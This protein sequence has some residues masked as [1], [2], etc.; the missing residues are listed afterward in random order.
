MRWALAGAGIAIVGLVV[1]L[2]VVLRDGDTPAT[3]FDS[4]PAGKTCA[5]LCEAE[6]QCHTATWDR[7]ACA[8]ACLQFAVL[9]E[10]QPACETALGDALACWWQSTERCAPKQSC[11]EAWSRAYG[12][13]CKLPDLSVEMRERCAEPTR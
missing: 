4:E 10:T 9:R 11:A 2:V 12:C 1:T 5:R 6:R 7:N 13:M 3:P 8:I